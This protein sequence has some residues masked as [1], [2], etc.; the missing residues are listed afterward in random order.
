M[1]RRFVPVGIAGFFRQIP[2]QNHRACH[3]NDHQRDRRKR[4]PE[5]L[6]AA[7]GTGLD[8]GIVGDFAGLF[9]NKNL[10][11]TFL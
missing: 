3:H 5:I 11:V 2:R 4:Y 6:Q 9:V 8:M 1:I 7:F 10:L